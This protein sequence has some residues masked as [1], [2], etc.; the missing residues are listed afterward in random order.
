[1]SLLTLVY[2]IVLF[3]ALVAALVYTYR[4]PTEVRATAARHGLF[5]L[6]GL[7]AVGAALT[8]W[9]GFGRFQLLAWALFLH[10]PL[11]FTGL[12]PL[13]WRQRRIAVAS[14]VIAVIAWGVGLEAFV[15]E[16]RWLEVT[17]L[18]IQ[19]DKID[20]PI[21][22][23]LLA[24]IQTDNAGAWER[25]VLAQVVAEEPDLIIFAGD[26]VQHHDPLEYQNT[27]ERLNI[28]IREAG[29]N[30][31]LGIIAARGNVD[32]RGWERIFEGTGAITPDAREVL[33]LGPVTVTALSLPE[34]F[35]GAE[36]D[37]V[38][39]F[40]IVVGHAPD[41]ALDTPPAEL[42]LAGHT[43][44]GQVRLPFL[45]PIFTLS[46]VPRDWAAGVSE[47]A[48]GSTLVVSRGIGME[49]DHAPRLRFLCRPEVVIITLVPAPGS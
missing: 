49:R 33:D 16:P 1:M 45:G 7:A 2:N 24:D 42:L 30:P 41:F 46:R 34:S 27:V 19:S 3:A 25:D 13:L 12:V 4:R 9:G 17:H 10:L 37:P 32:H 35:D 20:E 21:T 11:Y 29:L 43:H 39:D 5:F 23:A 48:P 6:C 40:H 38:T 44:G 18:E 31:P 15:I 14:L 28:I 8:P 26:Y 36:V 22:I 47:V